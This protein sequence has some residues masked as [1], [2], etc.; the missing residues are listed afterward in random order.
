MK[1]WV[2]T[3]FKTGYAHWFLDRYPGLYAPD[4]PMLAHL[5]YN[6]RMSCNLSDHVQSRIY[7]F[8]AYEPIETY[9]LGSLLKPDSIFFDVGANVG[10][11][12]LMLSRVCHRG[13]VFAF[14]PVDV[15]FQV[16]K[17]NIEN[18][19]LQ[20]S[21][22]SIKK[23]LWNENTTLE[24]S[25]PDEGGNNLGTYSAGSTRK[26]KNKTTC[27]VV[28]LDSFVESERLERLDALKMDIE[29][30]ELFALR[31]GRKTLKELRPIIQIELNAYGCKE[32][33]YSLNDIAR[34]LKSHDYV[35]YRVG[36][37]SEAS[38]FIENFDGI[39]QVNVIALPVEK[40]QMLNTQWVGQEICRSFLNV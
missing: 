18:N 37:I 34:E 22:T 31:G 10:F 30:A 14:E 11:Y 24:F 26:G 12:S 15:N 29:G 21:I 7:F 19:D 5:R 8:G 23:G 39:L 13:K 28:T 33:G 40:K 2:S 4:A 36:H 25:L 9:L 16:L 35:F 20:N 6:L 3:G 32:F 1:T 27:E 17:A 38:G